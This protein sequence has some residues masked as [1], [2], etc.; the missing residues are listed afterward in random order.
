MIHRLNSS[1]PSPPLSFLQRQLLW[2]YP[3]SPP[4]FSAS[5]SLRTSPVPASLL[6]SLLLEIWGKVKKYKLCNVS[7]RIK[8]KRNGTTPSIFYSGTGSRCAY[9]SSHHSHSG[10]KKRNER[11][12]FDE[13]DN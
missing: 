9:D 3:F 6:L 10:E 2:K 12:G 13:H 5:A 1:F 7:H 11:A 8:L 4:S